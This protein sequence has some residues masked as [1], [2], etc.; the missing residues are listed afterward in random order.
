MKRSITQA[1]AAALLGAFALSSAQAAST[2][3]IGAWAPTAWLG[4]ATATA[5]VDGNNTAYVVRVDLDAPGI[6]FTTTPLGAGF[7]PNTGTTGSA[8]YETFKR[9]GATYVQQTGVA[10][11]I[12]GNFFTNNDNTAAGTGLRGLAVDDGVLV[13]SAESDYPSLVIMQD[14]QASIVPGSTINP[15][16]AWNAVAGNAYLVANG[17]SLGGDASDAQRSAIGLTQDGN[18]LFL[19]ATVGAGTSSNSGTT[20][21]QTGDLLVALG[22]WTGINTSGGASSTLDLADGLGGVI[23]LNRPTD[24]SPG[25]VTTG[26]RWIGNFLGVVATPVPEP[27]AAWLMGAGLAG[28]GLL[29]ARRRRESL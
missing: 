13:S 11:A 25:N 18:T 19:V 27:G 12:T 10:A 23:K 9:Q 21:A 22:A 3:Q 14:G 2:V 16:G 28:I 8:A 17:T 5:V 29:A 15:A 26:E 20:F 1:A 4:I 6:G 7:A 24:G